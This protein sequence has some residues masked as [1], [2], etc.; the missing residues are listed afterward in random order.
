VNTTIHGVAL[1]QADGLDHLWYKMNRG[2]AGD[3]F[4]GTAS[5]TTFSHTS[6]PD[7]KS[8][9]GYATN[10]LADAI[11][12]PGA[13]MTAD[14][15]G[16]PVFPNLGAITPSVWYN[17]RDPIAVTVTGT[18]FLHGATFLLRDASLNEYEAD[19]IEWLG[20]GFLTGV[21]DLSGLAKGKYEVVVRNPN[22][23]EAS[24]PD[25]FEVK[26]IVPVFIQ[27]F[28]A[29]ATDKG[30][31]LTWDVWSDEAVDGFRILRREGDAAD[32]I[33]LAGG[34]LIGADL[35]EFVDD[36]VLPATDYEYTL[37]V[38]L[39]EGSQQRSQ[40]V[41]ARSAGFSLALLQNVPNPFNPTTTISFTLPERMP[42]TLTVYD[43]EGREIARIVDGTR[44]AGVSEVTWNGR[45]SSGE[46]VASGVYF[47]R[48]VAG[49]RV[50]TKKMLLLK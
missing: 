7:S 5:N 37:A 3:V 31:V 2:D 11:S 9:N 17:H 26:S 13:Q 48:L 19:T 24:I 23:Q 1:E 20:R 45:G 6:A 12:A 18:E 14:L 33:A 34:G 15:R 42:A 35:R 36:T 10:V 41:A 44:P 4:P 16:G 27:A 32:E 40:T 49:D 25:G 46:R 43:A 50:L 22:G 47:Y 21:L 28:D 30:V 39:A 38:V 8:Y 29:R